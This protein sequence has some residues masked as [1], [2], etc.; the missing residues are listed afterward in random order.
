MKRVF[1]VAAW[2]AILIVISLYFAAKDIAD[3]LAG[4]R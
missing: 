2:F 3:V 1:I 4:I